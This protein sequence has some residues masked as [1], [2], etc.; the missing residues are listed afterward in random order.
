M[1]N[2]TVDRLLAKAREV[3]HLEAEL[4]RA[5][6]EFATLAGGKVAAVTR[7]P[8][9]DSVSQRVLRVLESGPKA[10]KDI[11]AAIGPDD[12]PAVSSAIKKHAQLGRIEH[13]A[14]GLWALAKPAGTPTS[15]KTP[16]EIRKTK[17]RAP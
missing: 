5:R 12:A 13:T 10:R 6:E 1:T 2:G 15:H 4:A 7:G 11:V 16:V 14:D 17:G 9:S 3:A 8:G